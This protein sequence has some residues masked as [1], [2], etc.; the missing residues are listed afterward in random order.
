MKAVLVSCCILM[1]ANRADQDDDPGTAS[2][3]VAVCRKTYLKQL[4]RTNYDSVVRPCSPVM[5]E[6]SPSERGLIHDHS[7]TTER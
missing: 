5:V 7:I 6:S 1:F 2:Q 4:V 3:T